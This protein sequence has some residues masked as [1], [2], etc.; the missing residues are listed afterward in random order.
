M[1]SENVKKSGSIP[2]KFRTKYESPPSSGKGGGGGGGHPDTTMVKPHVRSDC[3]K[4]Q[5][6]AS[7]LWQRARYPPNWI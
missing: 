1:G 5:G 7:I 6:A 2:G 3:I 4:H